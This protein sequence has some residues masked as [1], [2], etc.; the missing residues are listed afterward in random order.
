MHFQ[1]DLN[2]TM[3]PPEVSSQMGHEAAANNGIRI[4]STNDQMQS[5]AFGTAPIVSIGQPP[6]PA[7]SGD[8]VLNPGEDNGNVEFVLHSTSIQSY[9]SRLPVCPGGLTS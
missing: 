9:L 8:E 3:G 1:T 7:H 5:S 2:A 4:S 6:A